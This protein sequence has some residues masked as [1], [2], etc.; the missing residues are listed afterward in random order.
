MRA[1]RP[2]TLDPAD[3]LTLILVFAAARLHGWFF[4]QGLPLWDDDF[5]WL[6]GRSAGEILWR[7]ISPV[8]TQPEHWGFN[9]RPGRRP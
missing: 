9:E 5:N 2:S 3:R 7:W 4:T 1:S 8:S 6:T